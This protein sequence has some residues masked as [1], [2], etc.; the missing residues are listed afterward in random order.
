MRD[1]L[2]NLSWFCK[3]QKFYAFVTGD[4]PS[5]VMT[6]GWT[7]NVSWLI[8]TARYNFSCGC[9]CVTLETAGMACVFRVVRDVSMSWGHSTQSR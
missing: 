8:T 5:N 9:L 4:Y 3:R 2:F 1:N 7:H 6:M